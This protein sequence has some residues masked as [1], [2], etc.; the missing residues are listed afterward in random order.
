MSDVASGS[1]KASDLE[2]V[3][4]LSLSLSLS[5]NCPR[6][7][8]CYE[9]SKSLKWIENTFMFFKLMMTYKFITL[10]LGGGNSSSI[11]ANM[12]LLHS[13]AAPS[14]QSKNSYKK[15]L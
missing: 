2:T 3:L 15:I 14:I 5:C 4:S 12:I 11:Q 8:L 6:C 13:D 10:K 7:T 1:I 9:H